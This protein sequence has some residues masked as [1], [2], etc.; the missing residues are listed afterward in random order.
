MLFR[1][2]PRLFVAFLALL[3]LSA[4]ALPP[5]TQQTPEDQRRHQV[6]QLTRR[7][8]ELFKHKKYDLVEATLTEALALDPNN[9]NN[10]YNMACVKALKGDP[11]TAIAYLERAAHAG[12]T[13][14]LHI[15]SDPDLEAL[16]HLDRYK[17][18]IAKKDFFQKQ[19]A[20]RALADL[21]DRFGDKYLYDIDAEAKLIFAADTDKQTLAAIKR[22]LTA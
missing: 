15:Q 13:D 8:V 3:A 4:Q 18:L 21:R 17:Q 7:A 5:P 19:D 12:F 10:I 14:F 11:A 9:A 2:I 16:R 1:S 6:L 20:Q 22:L